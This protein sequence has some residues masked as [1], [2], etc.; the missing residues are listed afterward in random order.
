MRL[1]DRSCALTAGIAGMGSDAGQ[2]R[3][4]Q[5]LA[6][7]RLADAPSLS[8]V[9]G[10]LAQARTLGMQRAEPAR[11]LCLHRMTSPDINGVIDKLI[12]MLQT[13]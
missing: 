5:A 1:P 7:Q 4:L 11:T 6:P 8:G 9:V 2:V 13:A 3:A 12:R 10:L